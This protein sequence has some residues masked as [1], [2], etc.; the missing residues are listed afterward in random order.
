[1][2]DKLVEIGGSGLKQSG[3]YI[4]EEFVQALRGQRGAKTYTEMGVNCTTVGMALL[5][6]E[7]TLNK[8]TWRVDPSDMHDPEAV[9]IAR[10]VEECRQ[11][12]GSSWA[13]T[14]SEVYTFLQYGY[15]PMEIVYKMRKGQKGD[16]R[17]KFTDG[18]VGWSKFALRAQESVTRWE[19]DE[20][21]GG[22]IKAMYQQPPPEF[23]ECVIP[24]ERLLLFRT[25]KH[26]NNPEGHSL[27]RAA[28]YP[29]RFWKGFT[30]QAAI[31]AE[32]DLGGIPVGIVPSF[33]LMP[34]APPEMKAA[35]QAM[36]KVVENLRIHEQASAVIAGDCDPVTGKPLFELRLLQ[37]GGAKQVDVLSLI[38]HCE[39]QIAL[40][41]LSD[42]ALIGHEGSGSFA[43]AQVSGD[44]MKGM[45]ESFLDRIADTVN[46]EAIPRLLELNGMPL[47][48]APAL[49]HSG[50][51][52]RDTLRL[53]QMLKTM[54]D[55]GE[56]VFPDEKLAR[57]LF[58]L[59]DLP[60]EG[61]EEMERGTNAA[62]AIPG[63]EGGDEPAIEI[64]GDEPSAAEPDAEPDAQAGTPP[65]K[66]LKAA[67]PEAG[68]R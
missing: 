2:A 4:Q 35:A 51:S 13:D 49:K 67:A 5:R 43:L 20:K 32:R 29:Y 65:V 37:S 50:I 10:F 46:R 64:P 6:L 18:K 8:T 17:S 55:A 47:E 36:Q 54:A 15:A 11:D 60:L 39:L 22:E 33:A 42:D 28:F 7:C 40:A 41:I 12:M 61:R 14:L 19:F 23:V 48:K 44:T 53:V 16:Q 63:G 68:E 1:M 30:E 38:K 3:G 57:Y 31:G 59:E 45:L 24:M 25:K 58:S 9:D 34:D 66:P 21:A 52:K 26:K 27:L 62:A 56:V